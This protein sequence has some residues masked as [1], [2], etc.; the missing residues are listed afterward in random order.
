MDLERAEV[1]EKNEWDYE[2]CG[3]VTM[4]S[5]KHYSSERSMILEFHTDNLQGNHTG[6]R[7]IFKFLDKGKFSVVINFFLV[8]FVHVPAHVHVYMHVYMYVH[9]CIMSQLPYI[10]INY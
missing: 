1:N 5:K 9:A 4:I 7:G 2:I 10:I 6:F 8:Q 3:N